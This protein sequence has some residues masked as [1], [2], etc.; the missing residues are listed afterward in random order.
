MAKLKKIYS[1]NFRNL[2]K[3]VFEF[4]DSINCFFGENGQG[5]TNILEAIY[6]LFNKRSFRKNASFP[7]LLSLECEKP[8][9]IIQS[10]VNQNDINNSLSCRISDKEYINSING[11]NTKKTPEIATLFI[12]PFE[13]SQF[14]STAKKRREVFDNFI[15]TLDMEYKKNLSKYDKVLRSKNRLL[16]INATDRELDAIDSVLSELIILIVK[17]RLKF[18]V[19][20]SSFLKVIFSEIFSEDHELE[21]E[22]SSLFLTSNVEIA[23]KMLK[24]AREKERVIGHSSSGV[25]RDD[26]VLYFDKLNAIDY[27][28][29]GQQKTSYF[30][31]IFAYIKLFRYKFNGIYP[32]LLMDDVS[33]ELDALRW[34]KLT[35]YI[36]SKEFQIFI[37][38]ANAAFYKELET[39]V[40][41][42]KFFI[43]QG[44]QR[45]I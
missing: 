26:F 41:A 29:L 16:A 1:E 32:I 6:V 27:C 23:N 18:I 4:S 17:R 33:G 7:Q 19:E 25:H 30:S 36:Q 2:D 38:T 35:H 3:T 5:K 40:G 22:L 11:K 21:L 24:K 8:Q 37:T 12:S 34:S 28:S 44:V 43:E 13:S 31:L 15:S 42:R 20:I 14:F 9:I 10:L 45:E 39:I